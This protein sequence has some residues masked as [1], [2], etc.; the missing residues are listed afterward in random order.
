MTSGHLRLAGRGLSGEP[1]WLEGGHLQSHPLS[2]RKGRGAGGQLNGWD[3]K[4]NPLFRVGCLET[5]LSLGVSRSHL[6]K[7]SPVVVEIDVLWIKDPQYF[8]Y[9]GNSRV[10]KLWIE[11]VD[12]VQINMKRI[13]W[14]TEWPIIYFW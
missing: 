14:S 10:W 3:W 13:F 5:S 8:Q 4:L 1:T 6:I 7:I 2:T 12:K 9:L 11:T